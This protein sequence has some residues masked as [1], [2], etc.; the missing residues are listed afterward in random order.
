MMMREGCGWVK[1]VLIGKFRMLDI[2]LEI[3]RLIDH[4]SHE[5]SIPNIYHPTP[6]PTS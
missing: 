1:T 2:T 6:S 5:T 4:R 3:H